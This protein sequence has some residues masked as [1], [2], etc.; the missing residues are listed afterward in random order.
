MDTEIKDI[1][2]LYEK[3]IKYLRWIQ[4]EKREGLTVK[5]AAWFLGV[6]IMGIH[7]G[8]RRGNIRRVESQTDKRVLV[9][10]QDILNQMK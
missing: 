10:I 6:S 8:M 3:R 2:H 1:V 5:E 9:N 7:N 4:D